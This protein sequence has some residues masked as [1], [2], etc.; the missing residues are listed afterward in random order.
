MLIS[1]CLPSVNHHNMS[2]TNK[3]SHPDGFF[4]HTAFCHLV[5][6]AL[7]SDHTI[8]FQAKI[9]KAYLNH[10]LFQWMTMNKSTFLCCLW[11]CSIQT[12][13]SLQPIHLLQCPNGLKIPQCQIFNWG[14]CYPSHNNWQ[15]LLVNQISMPPFP[16]LLSL[17]FPLGIMLSFDNHGDNK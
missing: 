16:L 6:V 14:E 13:T 1:N 9:K 15:W 3:D 7:L 12:W 4:L 5:P 11:W 10:L 8:V 17:P 2:K